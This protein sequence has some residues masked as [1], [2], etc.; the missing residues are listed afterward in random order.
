MELPK[1]RHL[2]QSQPVDLAAMAPPR[3]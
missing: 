2:P 3:S 1:R